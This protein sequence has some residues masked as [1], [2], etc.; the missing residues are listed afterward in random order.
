MEKVDILIPQCELER[1]N[2]YK[3]IDQFRV[4]NLDIMYHIHSP[5]YFTDSDYP[6]NTYCVWN[7]A[8]SGLVSYHIMNQTLQEPVTQ[9]CNG[10]GCDCPDYVKITMGSNEVKLCGN[11]MPSTPYLLSSN[12][13]HV[14]FCSDN[15]HTAKGIFIGAYKFSTYGIF[16]KR[17][18]VQ[19]QS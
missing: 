13:L 7:V 4:G 6:N 10:S 17:K 8:N 11:T 15:K 12:G 1:K 16:R 3:T 9:N 18:A 14:K 2:D 19:V 5:R